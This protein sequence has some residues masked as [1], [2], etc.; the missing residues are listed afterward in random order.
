MRTIIPVPSLFVV[1]FRKTGKMSKISF[2]TNFFAFQPPTSNT[3]SAFYSCCSLLFVPPVMQKKS[4][5]ASVNV[6]LCS[7]LFS[8]CFT[9]TF[10]PVRHESE[11]LHGIS[12]KPQSLFV[13]LSLQKGYFK[14][15]FHKLQLK[16]KWQHSKDLA[17]Y[18][19][20][21]Y[22]CH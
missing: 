7:H 13:F 8:V 9:A 4:Q 6:C 5:C 11:P 21:T 18:T 15:M 2:S 22:Q 16:Q 20:P 12:S 3:P 17:S 1:A 10:N 19:N 14:S